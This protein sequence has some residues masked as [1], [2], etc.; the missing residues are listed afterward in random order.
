VLGRALDWSAWTALGSRLDTPAGAVWNRVVGDGGPWT[1]FLH[2]FPT[3]SLD[4]APLFEAL[5][6]RDAD[7]DAPRRRLVVDLVGF[8][9]SERP[10]RTPRFAD[11]IRALAAVWK[12]HGV[13]E[14]ALVCH[15][16]S[17]SI[18]QEILWRD[19]HGGWTGPRITAVVLLNGGLFYSQQSRLWVQRLLA[20]PG[21]GP[22]VAAALPRASFERA[23]R[24]L[25]SVPPDAD[26]L[27][28]IW[29]GMVH[30]GK[31]SIARVG[32]YHAE[33]RRNEGRW[34]TALACAAMPT[35]L[36]W[37]DADPVSGARMAEHARRHCRILHQA[38]RA[39]LGHYP[40]VEDPA[41]VARWVARAERRTG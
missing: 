17:V 33:R 7:T 27:R 31:S 18:A 34:T 3:H 13:A 37:G 35:T 40:H 22:F 36:V 8:G 32:R 19:L 15:D 20:L 23:M 1:T 38:R 24:R 14:T 6:V 12:H 16:Y 28:E 5:A 41:W 11:Q 10:R 30:G 25:C 39:D 4:W 21:L 9:A 26:D 2:G 29:A